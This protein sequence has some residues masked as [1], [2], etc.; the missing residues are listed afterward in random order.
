[1]FRDV[2]DLINDPEIVHIL[3][4]FGCLGFLAISRPCSN[5][6]LERLDLDGE[7]L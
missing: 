5:E 4:S 1:M 2:F 6:L 7:S 3:D